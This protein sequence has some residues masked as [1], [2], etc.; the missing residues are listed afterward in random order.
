[1]GG[2]NS[3]R[4]VLYPQRLKICRNALLKEGQL[5]KSHQT[6][7]AVCIYVYSVALIALHEHFNRHW[8]LIFTWSFS[9]IK[10]AN[11]LELS[12]RFAGRPH[13]FLVR[14]YKRM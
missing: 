12:V 2:G 14:L 13:E 5:Y 1:M 9:S 3:L 7:M 11:L 10:Y 8:I 4:L 6:S